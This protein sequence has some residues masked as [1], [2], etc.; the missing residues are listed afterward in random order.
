MADFLVLDLH[1]FTVDVHFFQPFC[2]IHEMIF[3][4]IKRKAIYRGHIENRRQSLIVFVIVRCYFSNIFIQKRL[5]ESH[6]IPFTRICLCFERI[7]SI[8]LHLW[9]QKRQIVGLEL[10]GSKYLSCCTVKVVILC[11]WR[12]PSRNCLISCEPSI[13]V[14]QISVPIYLI[15]LIEIFVVIFP[16]FEHKY[17][18]G[19]RICQVEVI[20]SYDWRSRRISSERWVSVLNV[21]EVLVFITKKNLSDCPV[22]CKSIESD[23]NSKPSDVSHKFVSKMIRSNIF[24]DD[25]STKPFLKGK[26]RK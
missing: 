25:R 16:C 12:L 1:I 7:A 18:I 15:V 9:D 5:M 23:W 10:I 21:S 17:L 8:S 19:L 2:A 6:S 20:E 13:V 3:S 22:H 24:Q 11:P 26:E 14:H 4:S